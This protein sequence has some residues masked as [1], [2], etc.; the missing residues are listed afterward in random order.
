MSG[1]RG[2]VRANIINGKPPNYLQDVHRKDEQK[3]L[4]Q[5]SG[6]DCWISPKK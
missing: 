6:A 5:V 3:E 1:S 4:T 2:E